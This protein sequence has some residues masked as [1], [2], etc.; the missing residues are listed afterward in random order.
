M[1]KYREISH[2]LFLKKIFK[3]EGNA[4]NKKTIPMYF[5]TN[6]FRLKFDSLLI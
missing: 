6:F 3:F 2:F 5:V 4:I 1:K